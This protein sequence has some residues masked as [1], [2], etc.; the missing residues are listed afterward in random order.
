VEEGAPAGYITFSL[1]ENSSRPDKIH[2]FVKEIQLIKAMYGKEVVKV[3][4][5]ATMSMADQAKLVSNSAVL[6]TNHGGVGGVSVFL[7]KGASVIIFWHNER[8][9]DS[10]FYESAGYFRVNWVSNEERSFVNRTISLIDTEV[11]KTALQWPDIL[12][13][14]QKFPNSKVA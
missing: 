14:R 1:S 8:R 10:N 3:V 13:A 6:L 9:F 5:M 2:D 11:E 7:Q 12:A 4:D